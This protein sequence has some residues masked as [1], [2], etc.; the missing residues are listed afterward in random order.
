MPKETFKSA[1]QSG[2]TLLG[3]FLQ[4][5]TPE[6]AEIVG[7]AEFDCGIVDTEHGMMGVDESLR[8]IRGCDAGGLIPVYRV[9]GTDHHRIGLA[10]DMGASAVMVPNITDRANAEGVIN[11]AKYHPEGN[12]GVCIYTRGADYD[13]ESEGPEYYS[14]A[15]RETAVILQIEG[16][17]GMAHLDDILDVPHLDC[18]FVGPF[19]L[20]QSLGIPGQVTDK[21]VLEAIRDIVARA[22]QRR[23]AVANFAVSLEQARLYADMGVRFIAYGVD[24]MITARAY[25]DLRKALCQNES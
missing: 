18:I 15:N 1:L 22:E 14:R 17:E 20:S 7:A 9:P 5:P 21:R 12:R 24:S 19:D 3:T 4:I 23:I 11:A 13:A 8:L 6:L 10:L 2:R 16:P 25:K